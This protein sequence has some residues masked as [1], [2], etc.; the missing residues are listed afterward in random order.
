MPPLKQHIYFSQMLRQNTKNKRAVSAF[1]LEQ[2][3]RQ[4]NVNKKLNEL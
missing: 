2:V 3:Y 1:A 4:K